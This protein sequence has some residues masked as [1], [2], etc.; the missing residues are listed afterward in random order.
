MNDFGD[1]PERD[2]RDDVIDLL[3][4]G[5][6]APIQDLPIAETDIQV[7]HNSA[8]KVTLLYS[9]SSVGYLLTAGPS[10]KE[11]RTNGTGHAL[12][13]ETKAITE[14]FTFEVSAKKSKRDAVDVHQTVRVHV[15]LDTALPAQIM[16]DDEFNVR[17]LERAAE[18]PL[19]GAPRLAPYGAVILVEIRD[20][21]EGVDYALELEP[22]TDGKPGK[23]ISPAV[24]GRGFGQAIIL[25]SEPLKISDSVLRVRATSRFG[26]TQSQLLDQRLPLMIEPSPEIN[27]DLAPQVSAWHQQAKLTLAKPQTGVSYRVFGRT[28]QDTEY[29]RKDLPKN[30]VARVSLPDVVDAW[31]ALPDRIYD[32]RIPHGFAPLGLAQTA[33]DGPLSFDLQQAERDK[34]LLIHATRTHT[35]PDLPPITSETV[36]ATYLVQLVAPDPDPPLSLVLNTGTGAVTVGQGQEGIYYHLR[37]AAEAG[38]EFRRPAYVH[39]RDPNG[40]KINKGVGGLQIGVDMAVACDAD[41]PIGQ[42]LRNRAS[43]EP[44][45]PVVET[46]GLAPGGQIHL[47]AV[48]AQSLVDVPITRHAVIP[49]H[50][51]ATPSAN[52]VA[53]GKTAEIVVAKSDAKDSYQIVIAGE[54]GSAKKGTGAQLKFRTPKLDEDTVI[55]LRATRDAGK[56]LP[57]V[58]ELHI[59]ITVAEPPIEEDPDEPADSLDASDTED[60]VLEEDVVDDDL[61]EEDADEDVDPDPV[62]TNE[63]VEEDPVEP[64][65]PDE[66]PVEPDDP[67]EP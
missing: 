45:E 7:P 36:M 44:S 20:G 31:I 38:A 51:D 11:K 59:P 39:K 40:L 21:Q 3:G 54:A 42:T 1:I 49:P 24:R 34:V 56:T 19:P 10:A 63:P 28:I 17:A 29:R 18:V 16:L 23:A 66:D 67:V 6:T 12:T 9:Q 37:P 33:K 14:P 58:R 53:P 47:R 30:R 35:W 13:L 32:G 50:P 60:I 65:A 41:P 43:A 46:K 61:A 57:L 4:L 48:K 27:P 5:R 2:A 64:V 8:A 25:Q 22:A 26:Q 15:G 52:P 62:D 55:V